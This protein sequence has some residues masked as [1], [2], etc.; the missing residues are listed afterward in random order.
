MLIFIYGNDSFQ[1]QRK[2]R[3]MRE[4]FLNKFDNQNLN[5][6]VFPTANS[7][8]I[9]VSEIFQIMATS[10]FLC[11]KRMVI[12]RDFFTNVKTIDEVYWQERLLAIPS[13]TIFILSQEIEVKQFEKKTLVSFFKNKPDVYFYSLNELTGR[14]LE[15]EIETQAKELG[16]VLNKE[17][18]SA[19]IERLGSDLWQIQTS[20]QKLCAY[21]NGEPVSMEMIEMFVPC[22]FDDQIFALMD[23]LSSK[24][25]LNVV[26]L[27]KQQ[28]LF[29][30][31]DFYLFS[32][33]I[34]QI[35]LLLQ[36]KLFFEDHPSAQASELAK[37]VSIHPYVAKKLVG[38]IHSFSISDLQ[39]AHQ[40][41]FELDHA[42]KNGLVSSGLALDL[43]VSKFICLKQTK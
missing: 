34:R 43:F 15:K 33:F 37:T 17:I 35:R 4:Q 21:A 31:N 30:S 25:D 22:F 14:A 6:S 41:L 2:L 7:N 12:V 5:L 28:R 11:E 10:P 26:Q 1:I 3:L 23:A 24:R 32:M 20:L 42:S 19:I 13:S 9:T 29:G 39:T 8:Q 16:V 36:A 38:Q 27:L 40:F 18:I